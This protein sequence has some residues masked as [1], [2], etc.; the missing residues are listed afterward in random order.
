MKSSFK[1]LKAGLLC[2]AV[3]IGCTALLPASAD[4]SQ[5][6]TSVTAQAVNT[7]VYDGDKMSTFSSRT[8]ESVAKKYTDAYYAGASYVN[9]DSSTYYSTPAST[10]SPYNQGVLSK[11]TLK[12]MQEM[13]NF[14]RWLVG[15][16]PLVVECTQNDSLQCQ[17]LD[18]NFEFNHKISQSSKPEDMP[19]EL[20]QKGYAC[21][22]NIL[23]WGYT[24]LDSITGWMNEGYYLSSKKWDTLGHRYA[25]I[26]P[27]NLDVQFGYCGT[28]GIGK[29]NYY[30]KASSYQPFYAFPSPGYV[31]AD[32]ISPT[33]S[34]WSVD[35]DTSK[36]K[37]TD[38]SAVKVTVTNLSTKT[39]YECT[40]SNDKASVSSS[41]IAFV[42]PS[43]YDK[44]TY[45]Y[46]DSFKVVITGLT[47]VATGNP[48]Q[49]QYTVKF[50][51]LKDHAQG[52][53]TS[54]GFDYKKV[55]FYNGYYTDTESLKKLGA[56]LPTTV[57]VTNEFGNKVQVKAKGKWTLDEANKCWY[58]SVDP[59]AVPS[60]FVDTNGLL[61]KLTIGYEST[62]DSYDVYNTLSIYPSDTTCGNNVRFSIHRTLT[63]YRTTLLG[64]IAKDSSGN[65]YCKKSYDSLTSPEFDSE[66]SGTYHYYNIK[67]TEADSGEYIS[68]YYYSGGSWDTAYA[69]NIPRTLTVSHNYELFSTKEPTCTE[70]GSKT[71]KCSGCGKKK[72]ETIKATG[73]S[74][75]S[76]TYTWSSDGKTCTAKR[77]CANDSAHVESESAAIASKVKTP[78]TCAVKGTT[79]YTATFKNTAFK[80]QTKNVQDIALVAHTWGSWT[81]TKAATCSAKGT[82]TRTCSVCKK[83]ATADIAINANAHSWQA[84]TYTWS[85][86]GKNC[87]A[88]R[89]C[90]HDSAHVESESAVIASKVK[91]PATCAVKGTTTYT[92]TF[93]NTAFKTQTKDVQDI[94]LVAHT[95]GSWTTTKAATCS[96]K[97]TKTRTC[98][99][100]KK[101]ATADIAINANAHSWQAPTYSWSSDGKTCTAK[102]V[103]ANDSA[104]VESESAAIASKVKTPATCA[105][106]GTTTYTATFKNTAFK[107]QTKD[108]QD[109]ALV[110]HTWGSWTT[111]KAATCS[112]KGTKQ[113]TCSVCKK[114]ATA[115]IAIN[116]NAHSWQSP[117][118]SWSADGKNCTAKRVC[119]HD[120]AHVETESAAIASKVKTPATCAVKGTTTYTATFKNTAFKT[121]TKN[122][123][124]IAL[125]AHTW[126]SWKKT[127]FDVSAGTRLESRSCKVCK[128]TENRS[129]ENG[130]VRL[131]GKGRYETA[132]EISRAS[133]T[134]GDTVVLAYSMNYADALAGV[135]LAHKLGAPILLNDT[136]TLDKAT[137]AEIKRIGAKN[138]IILGGEGAISKEVENALAKEDLTTRRI[139]GSTRFST[140]T[141]IA[142]QLNSAPQEVFFVYGFNYADALSVSTVA[143]VKGAPIIYLSTSG[144]L[145]HDTADYLAKI[146]GRVKNAYVIGGEGVISDDMM[147]KAAKALGLK[148]AARVA[149]KDRYLTCVEVNKAFAE[150]L[151]GKAVCIATGLAFPDA[152]AGGVFAA[153][154]KAPLFLA[155]NSLS[156]AQA[157]YL[158]SKDPDNI[159][160]FG[161]TG[162]VPD[163]LV[164]TVAKACV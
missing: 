162:A 6:E 133:G 130:V 48:A 150:T 68:L 73:H 2:A 129:I 79:T 143:A 42:Q 96:A 81:T 112:A 104:H 46:T 28:I 156:S 86:D 95:W 139:A 10:E 128:K 12:C 135:P 49:V 124:D 25:L 123:Q 127:G 82:K 87:T 35:F 85:S 111:T 74:W 141:A 157:E 84:P 83:V 55:L 41:S 115:D 120:S 80:T 62:D 144:E 56:L 99:V 16:E 154:K 44:S 57:T 163:S 151:T 93:K 47:D 23:A 101:V 88:K 94:A 106:K 26:S 34:A 54:A 109:I 65:Y 164:N 92:A 110:A 107:T 24:P 137:L 132:V 91:T 126:G 64:L 142:E 134:K 140:A 11:D 131:A 77:V 117:T 14:Y 13:T 32:C 67:A 45:N 21:Q 8:P 78:A 3:L 17:A 97:G 27:D 60:K 159:Y 7:V 90:A 43:E 22:H 31:P 161:G 63:T 52:R 15:N 36:I 152:L 19:D 30:T 119:A 98:S 138:V 103:C 116:A 113:R 72:T 39:S 146:K 75:K 155:D 9:S 37:V 29:Y 18:R 160:V 4:I 76:P 5:S 118:Y 71:Y 108:V 59:S 102:R 153:G 20:W 69:C 70:A 158:K 66:G 105:V 89:V 53:I 50:F 114:V 51:D 61:K 1:K 100:C 40:S 33:Y 148:S 38:T 147:N 122:V 149:G 136:K 125:V 145:D 58:N 121:Q